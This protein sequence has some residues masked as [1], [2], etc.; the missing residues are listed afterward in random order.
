MALS[1]FN[2][3]SIG[4]DGVTVSGIDAVTSVSDGQ[5]YGTIARAKKSDG[6]LGAIFMAKGTYT[7]E[8]SGYSHAISAPGLGGSISGVGGS[9]KIMSS[10]LD[11][12]NQDFVKVS[13]TGKGL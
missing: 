11:A 10:K 12:S 3:A 2:N 9:Q 8:V 5:E 13:V 4:V 6:E 1:T 7:S